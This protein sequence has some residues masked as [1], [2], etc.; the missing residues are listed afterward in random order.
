MYRH[1]A[2]ELT[3]ELIKLKFEFENVTPATLSRF[4]SADTHATSLDSGEEHVFRD[5][6]S[7]FL[8]GK[9]M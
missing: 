6:A 2:A 3:Q 8:P 1:F 7:R 5:K 9:Q 4:D